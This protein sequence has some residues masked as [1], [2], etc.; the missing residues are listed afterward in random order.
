V[1][2]QNEEQSKMMQ[3]YAKQNKLANKKFGGDMS[4][5]TKKKEDFGERKIFKYVPAE[6]P[7]CQECC[8]HSAEFQQ[9]HYMLHVSI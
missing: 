6:W 8:H 2:E 4:L 5:N 3:E 7:A 1:R 9:R